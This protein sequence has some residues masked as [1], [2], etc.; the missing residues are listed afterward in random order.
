MID[1]IIRK[2]LKIFYHELNVHILAP[3][4][5]FIDESADTVMRIVNYKIGQQIHKKFR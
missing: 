4:G 3:Y 1:I 2:G 5:S